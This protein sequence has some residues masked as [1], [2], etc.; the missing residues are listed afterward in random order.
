MLEQSGHLGAAR[1]PQREGG[2][3][4]FVARAEVGLGHQVRIDDGDAGIAVDPGGVVLLL[5]LRPQPVELPV[6][7]P[8]SWTSDQPGA[9]GVLQPEE[10]L[11]F[12]LGDL[13]GQHYQLV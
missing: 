11:E 9:G 8:R 10:L 1:A 2:I 3:G 12:G 6:E 5:P 7:Q 13:F 4:V